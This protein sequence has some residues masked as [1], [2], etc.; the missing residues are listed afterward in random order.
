MAENLPIAT[1]APARGFADI[2]GLKQVGLLAGVAAAVAAAIWLVMWSQ[3]QNYTVLYGQLSER[4]SGQVMDAL[5]AAGIEF[6]LNPSGAVSVPESKVQEARIRLASQGLPQS[7]SMGIEMIQKESAL[8]SSS[9]METARYQ[10]VLETELARTIIKVQGVQ[11]ARVHLALPKASVFLRDSHKATASVMLQ[12][13]PGRRLEPGQVAAVVHL[14]ASSV[15]EL[16]ASDVT[17][18]DQ[19]GSLLNSPD[20]NAES[21]MSTRQFEYTRKLEESYQRRIIDLLEPMLG[22]G[23]VRATVTADLDFTITE[24]TRENYDPQKTAVRSEQTSSETRKGGDGAEGI[25][26]ALS[27]QPPGTSGAPSIPGAATPGNPAPTAAGAQGA[28][29]QAAAAQAG[30]GQTTAVNTGP[31]S[32]AQRSTRNFEVDRTLSYVKQPVG[33]LK[34]LNVGVVLDD[35]QKVDADGKVTTA[36]MSDTDVKRFTQ[37]VKESIGLKEDRGDQLNVLN[38]AFKGSPA[39]GPVDGLPLWQQPWLTQL[40][41]QIVGAALVLVVAFLVLR[42]L[43]KSLTKPARRASAGAGDDLEGDRL[44][45]SGQGGKPIKLAPSFEQQIAAARTLVGQ[46]PRRAAQVVKEWVSADG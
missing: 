5:T 36:P 26:G 43:M 11:T 9:M 21:T 20:E 1:P 2:P 46:D 31:S 14:V 44:S 32:S 42:P 45:L 3:G 25:P 40:A 6:K 8:G 16:S 27:N 39:L 13:Y 15:P 28:A 30:A 41:K 29:A 18:V 17:L 23:R 33:V 37:L 34:R 7:D 35:W 19:A 10:S 24:E 12:L 22:P 38:Q 4:E